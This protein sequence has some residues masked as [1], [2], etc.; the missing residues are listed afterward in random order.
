MGHITPSPVFP[1][2]LQ[3][4][5]SIFQCLRDCGRCVE[6]WSILGFAGMDFFGEDNIKNWGRNFSAEHTG[7]VFMASTSWLW[8]WCNQVAFAGES[9]RLAKLFHLIYASVE[10]IK[11]FCSK[12]VDFSIDASPDSRCRPPTSFVETNVDRSVIFT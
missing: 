3:E 12:A 5:E 4:L 11:R 6:V 1:I 7:A 9:R 2:C 8:R 10:G